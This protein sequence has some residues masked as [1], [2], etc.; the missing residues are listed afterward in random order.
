MLWLGKPLFLPLMSLAES[1]A[2]IYLLMLGI[3][4]FDTL[5]IVPFAEL[6]LARRAWLY[7]TL[8]IVHVIVNVALNF[9]LIL[10]AGF[11]IE[12]VFLANLVAAVLVSLLVWWVTGDGWSG[13]FDGGVLKTC[14]Q[15][16]W[17][18]V[19]SGFGHVTNDMLDRFFL[20]IMDESTIFNLYGASL[21]PEDFVGIYSACYILSVYMMLLYQM[22]RMALDT[23]FISS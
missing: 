4:W 10:S 12:A 1:H 23:L 17:P 22:F 14:L 9:Y 11:G 2:E 18:F 8:R 7:A 21:T 3:L 13:E 6:R 5:S 16:G 15:F 19:F 20:N